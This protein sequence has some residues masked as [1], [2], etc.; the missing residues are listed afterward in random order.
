MISMIA[1]IQNDGGIGYRGE[2]LWHLKEDMEIFKQVTMGETVVMGRKT[3]EGI[4]NGLP[5]R[6]PVVL[7]STD[8]EGVACVRSVEDIRRMARAQNIFIVGGASLY[9]EFLPDTTWLYLTEV[10]DTKPAD[11]FF[12][13]LDS[14]DW[15]EIAHSSLCRF[16]GEPPARFRILKNPNARVL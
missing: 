11:T 1:C 8:L 3:W 12:P 9:R 4:P 2:L 5:G 15:L 16:E 6:R 10:Y 14:E 13:E 7:T